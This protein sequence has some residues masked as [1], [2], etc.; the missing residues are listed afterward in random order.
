LDTYIPLDHLW[1]RRENPAGPDVLDPCHSGHI[2]GLVNHTTYCVSGK[3]W[4][5]VNH[6]QSQNP[7][8][9]VFSDSFVL[10]DCEI[11]T[12]TKANLE[13]AFLQNSVLQ[14]RWNKTHIRV[15]V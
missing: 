8:V 3:A 12:T 1:A 4:A 6:F 13:A 7:H 11:E 9:E 5:V 10:T 2:F 14:E 15:P